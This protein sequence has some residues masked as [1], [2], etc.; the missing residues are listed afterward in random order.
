[1]DVVLRPQYGTEVVQSPGE[2]LTRSIWAHELNLHIA[3]VSRKYST[4]SLGASDLPAR[5]VYNCT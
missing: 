5:I 1:M 4:T 2:L 3:A